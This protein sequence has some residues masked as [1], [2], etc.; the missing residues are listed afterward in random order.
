MIQL[1]AKDG[2]LDH[3]F[4]I[5]KNVH[6]T[7][8]V[9]DIWVTTTNQKALT[10]SELDQVVEN[11]RQQ[12]IQG[13]DLIYQRLGDYNKLLNEK[14]ISDEKYLRKQTSTEK[15]NK[16]ELDLESKLDNFD[17]NDETFKQRRITLDQEAQQA[18]ELA[19]APAKEHK[20]LQEEDD[21]LL[22][23]SLGQCNPRV[24]DIIE[25]LVTKKDNPLWKYEYDFYMRNYPHHHAW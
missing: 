13:L 19:E 23:Y 2:Q 1:K 12:M 5:T 22:F 14:K 3:I 8:K 9:N 15:L 18:K 24:Q 25:K 4:R 17:E 21:M 20:R 7:N 10:I 11:S 16:I 6:S